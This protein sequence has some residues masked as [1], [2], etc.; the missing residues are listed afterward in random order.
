MSTPNITSAI[1]TISPQ[2]ALLMLETSHGNRSLKSSKVAA[3]ARDMAAGRWQ[4]NGEPIIID[5]NGALIDGHHRLRACINSEEPFQSF[6]IRGVSPESQKTIDMGA[7]RS[8]SDALTFYGIKD[9][10]KVNAAIRVLMALA[11]GRARSAN[12]STQEV[13]AFLEGNPLLSQSVRLCDKVR[14]VN[15][16]VTAIHYIATINGE[17]DLADSFVGVFKTG[18]PAYDGC[19]AHYARERITQDIMFRKSLSP[20]E[21]QLVVVAAWEN[22]RA[23]KSVKFLKTTTTKFAVT[24]WPK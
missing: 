20:R 16:V 1:E 23:R 2:K 24:G 11:S 6:V 10:T 3:Y 7:S 13:F 15:S 12:P 21:R 17:S 5:R 19:P 9:A 8:A 4:V 18:V 14:M 22:F